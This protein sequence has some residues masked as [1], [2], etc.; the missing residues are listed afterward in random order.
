M[1]GGMP[2]LG[3]CDRQPAHDLGEETFSILW[4]DVASTEWLSN[5]DLN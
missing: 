3:V 2:A 5:F 1:M 4:Q